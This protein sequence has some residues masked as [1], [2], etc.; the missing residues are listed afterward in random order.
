M[1]NPCLRYLE[2]LRKAMK[3][4][5][6]AST[7]VALFSI[8]GCAAPDS[9]YSSGSSQDPK[10]LEASRESYRVSGISRRKQ[11]FTVQGKH[12]K[13][14]LFNCKFFSTRSEKRL[15]ITCYQT[16]QPIRLNDFRLWLKVA[17]REVDAKMVRH[18]RWGTGTLEKGA[19]I[20]WEFNNAPRGVPLRVQIDQGPVSV[21]ELK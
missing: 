2:D 7:I 11:E 19:T 4:I 16:E 6:Y 8:H 13:G 18:P 12:E 1:M 14:Q 21:V 17:G 5:L 20:V 9:E 3:T 10:N 15:T